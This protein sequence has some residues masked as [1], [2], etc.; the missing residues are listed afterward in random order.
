MQVGMGFFAS[1]TRLSAVEVGVFT[2]LAAEPSSADALGERLGLHHRGRRDFLDGVVALG[3]LDR[4]GDG[5]DAV[6]SNA[7][8][9]A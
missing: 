3:F 1:K 8:D 2:E 6:S 7:A 5:P 9:A 4:P